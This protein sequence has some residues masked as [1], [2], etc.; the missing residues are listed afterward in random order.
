M[1]SP[2]RSLRLTRNK[3]EFEI[4]ITFVNFFH[5][6]GGLPLYWPPDQGVISPF[7]IEA[8]LNIHMVKCTNPGS[9]DG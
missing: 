9:I 1:Q 4:T 6:V 8:C 5:A 7:K 3:E 2:C